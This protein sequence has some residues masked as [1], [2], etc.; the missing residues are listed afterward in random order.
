MTFSFMCTP[1]MYS[2]CLSEMKC[3]HTT[4]RKLLPL[5]VLHV[6][7]FRMHPVKHSKP[8]HIIY[9]KL[10]GFFLQMEMILLDL[11]HQNHLCF[12][13]QNLGCELVCQ[14]SPKINVVCLVVSALL[15]N[16]RKN[17]NVMRRT[18]VVFM[19]MCVKRSLSQSTTTS[20]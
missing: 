5:L 19:N 15:K 14:H 13:A 10:N 16:K 4:A 12:F 11:F 9:A 7:N 20:V 17:S 18:N 3:R 6:V 1:N 8:S 2:R